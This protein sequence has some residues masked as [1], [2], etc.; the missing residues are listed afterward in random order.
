[1]SRIHYINVGPIASGSNVY[2]GWKLPRK[3]KQYVSVVNGAI[4]Y[5]YSFVNNEWRKTDSND[6]ESFMDTNKNVVIKVKTAQGDNDNGTSRVTPVN[7]VV[8]YN[9]TTGDAVRATSA[10]ATFT[11]TATP[12]SGYAV[13]KW[14]K[15]E[16]TA[17]SWSDISN[18]ATNE[19]T[20]EL[21]VNG[22]YK[23][24]FAEVISN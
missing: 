19:I 8:T 22:S 16:G 4:A 2:K 10:K 5:K 17:S 24:I 15:K 1:M 13:S 11:L 14:Q 23:A 6:V 18:S 9:S 20:V 21:D 12:D 3:N 7:N